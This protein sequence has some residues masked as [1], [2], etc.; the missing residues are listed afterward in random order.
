MKKKITAVL[1][2]LCF[3]SMLVFAQSPATV[4]EWLRQALNKSNTALTLARRNY[5]ANEDTINR[6]FEE[7][8]DLMLKIQNYFNQ[9]IIPTD[10]QINK[11]NQ[12]NANIA[13]LN[14][15]MAR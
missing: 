5:D 15:R 13:E 1:L 4:N 12:F 7:M 9:G 14:Q 3:G 11:V 6:L 2:L 8:T 10:D